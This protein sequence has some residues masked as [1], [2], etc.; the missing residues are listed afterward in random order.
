[1]GEA[2]LIEVIVP[3][4]RLCSCCCPITT[5]IS[6][7]RVEAFLGG[8]VYEHTYPN[9]VSVDTKIVWD[10]KTSAGSQAAAGFYRIVVSTTD[11]GDVQTYIK[12]VDRA[13]C[14]SLLCTR[15]SKPCGVPICNIHLKLSPI[16]TCGPCC[17]P[18]CD[19][20]CLYPFYMTG[21]G[22]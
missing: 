2:I 10:Q 20:C 18:C 5:Q 22:R 13:D 4:G 17:D 14:R 6:G 7:W 15:P 11:Q 16:P 9:P 19:P 21:T 8:V 1:L 3:Q 12:L